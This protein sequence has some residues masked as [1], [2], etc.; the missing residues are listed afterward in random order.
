MLKICKCCGTMLDKSNTEFIGI[1][2]GLDERLK[3]YNC[4]DCGSTI[5]MPFKSEED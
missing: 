4:N 3:L 1:Q 2:E 5:A